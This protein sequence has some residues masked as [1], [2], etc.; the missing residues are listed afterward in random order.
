MVEGAA[1]AAVFSFAPEGK[2]ERMLKLHLWSAPVRNL[3][4]V[5]ASFGYR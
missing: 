1:E 4:W 5:A 3:V 2:R